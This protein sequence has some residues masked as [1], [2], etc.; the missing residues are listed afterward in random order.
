MW[1]WEHLA[2]A[3]VLYSLITNVVV[4]ESPSAHET[5]A[6][7]LGSQL[8]DLVDKP[9]AWMAGITETGYAI[10]YSIFVA[11]F[12]WLVAYG[13]ARRRRSPR[14]AGAFSLAYLSHL[15]TDVRNPLR[16]GRE[17]EL[18]VVP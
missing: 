4:R 17:P 9:L 3:Y 7:V 15:V 11:P 8:P 1:P 2:V 16:M 5:V 10:G 18:R 6:V 12:V 14:L 13:I